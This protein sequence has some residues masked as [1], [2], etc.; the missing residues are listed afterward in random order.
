MAITDTAQ[1]A[2]VSSGAQEEPTRQQRLIQKVAVITGGNRGLGKI[3]GEAFTREGAN[4]V[5]AARP[6][7]TTTRTAKE[8]EAMGN[9]P[10]LVVPCDVS[11]EEDI[12]NV[13]KE[14]DSSFGRVDILVNNAAISGPTK[15][16]ADLELSEWNETIQIDL[17]GQFLCARE[18]V[19]RMIPKR[20]G[21]I[22]NIG[23]VFGPRRP[24]PLRSP[25]AAS[26]AGL[27]ALTQALAWEVGREGIRVNAIL[28]GP[29]EGDRIRRVWT[30]RAEARGVPFERIQDKMLGMAA[31]KRLPTTDEF[32]SL[33]LFLCSS[34]SGAITGQAINLTAGMEMR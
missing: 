11:S 32:A 10:V 28:P 17:T 20:S 16:V 19:R 24:Y 23:S 8:L 29:V 26:K 25:Y 4:I 27:V 21:A 7:E 3:L 18:A 14:V 30:A 33:A 15:A 9:R 31:M 12:V 5:I 22:L 34:D 6:S 2:S 1:G 13:F